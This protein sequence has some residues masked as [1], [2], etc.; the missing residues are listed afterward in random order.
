MV[1]KC[2]NGDERSY[3]QEVK[4]LARWCGDRNLVPNA[5]EMIVDY[6]ESA[7]TNPPPPS[8]RR[9]G[10]GLVAVKSCSVDVAP[11]P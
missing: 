6:C 1:A 9:R 11:L 2:V 3:R 4:D 5:K 8:P 7:P 10:G